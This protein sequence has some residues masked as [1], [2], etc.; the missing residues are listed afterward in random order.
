MNN[1]KYTVQLSYI[2]ITVTV[3]IMSAIMIES[4]E[5]VRIRVSIRIALVSCL[6]LEQ[7]YDTAIKETVR[8]N[9]STASCCSVI[10]AARLE[11][12]EQIIKLVSHFPLYARE[13]AI[14]R[15]LAHILGDE[16]FGPHTVVDGE[17]T[18]P[19]YTMQFAPAEWANYRS[20]TRELL[21]NLLRFGNQYHLHVNH[22]A[23]VRG[24]DT[25][26]RGELGTVTE[27]EGARFL[28]ISEDIQR[29]SGALSNKAA[30]ALVY[31]RRKKSVYNTVGGGIAE[32]L[33]QL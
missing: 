9:T 13:H 4:A 21:C 8:S 12:V 18:E 14:D 5:D 1:I 7:I 19:R 27:M 10:N 2:F 6:Q 17:T 22:I 30:A 20:L 25:D 26:M 23:I 31:E 29:A 16:T 28:T 33:S 24:S 11:I 15:E 32:P 3:A